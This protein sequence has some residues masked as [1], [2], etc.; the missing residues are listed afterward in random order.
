MKRSLQV[1]P[2]QLLSVLLILFAPVGLVFS[3][4][5]L[6]PSQ[7]LRDLISMSTRTRTLS[8]LSPG[9]LSWQEGSSTGD[10]HNQALA[11][12]E[13]IRRPTTVDPFQTPKTIVPSAIVQT[14]IVGVHPVD[15]RDQEPPRNPLSKAEAPQMTSGS[16]FNRTTSGFFA[17]RTQEQN[18]STNTDTPSTISRKP[19]NRFEP[20]GLVYRNQIS[21]T[22]LNS[23]NQTTNSGL[24]HS[25]FSGTENDVTPSAKGLLEN[26]DTG[27][28][29]VEDP[30]DPIQH[31]SSPLISP[32]KTHKGQNEDKSAPHHTITLRDVSSTENPTLPLETLGETLAQTDIQSPS[33]ALAPPSTTSNNSSG[34]SGSSAEVQG[35]SNGTTNMTIDSLV[36]LT[37]VTDVINSTGASWPAANDPDTSEAPSTASGSF[38]NRQVPATTQGP[39]GSGNQS[40]PALGPNH[41]KFTICLNKMDIVWLVLAISVPVS[42]CSV[43]LTICCMRKKKKSS[44]Q[45]NNLSYWNDA[46]TM[47]Y[48]T[49]HAVELPREIQSLETEDQETCLPPNGDYSDSGVVLVNPFCQETLF[50]NRDKASDI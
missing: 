6:Y 39:W 35:G 20:S 45:E 2:H 36:S 42:S 41:K 3:A 19:V 47:D 13:A 18:F 21:A 8:T 32:L 49:R 22:A 29:G 14:S 17:P 12:L 11:S 9:S 26:P 15:P 50:I 44:S 33:P 5:E 16:M 23:G 7:T 37:N 28:M 46:I 31:Q 30:I 40:G 43:L 27:E 38:M 24:G 4:E 34:E 10:L 25:L 1:L 48:F